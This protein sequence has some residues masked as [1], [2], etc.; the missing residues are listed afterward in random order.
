MG[1]ANT[2]PQ[3]GAKMGGVVGSSDGAAQQDAGAGAS[4]VG[5][6][7][8]GGPLLP[9]KLRQYVSVVRHAHRMDQEKGNPWRYSPDARLHPYDSPLTPKGRRT[10]ADVGKEL[11]RF[12]SVTAWS[13]I[14]SSPYLRCIQTASE[15]AKV[16]DLPIILDVEFGEVFDDVYMPGANNKPQYRE[17]SEIQKLMSQE[18]PGVTIVADE[19]GA[20]KHFG[21]LPTWPESFAAAQVRFLERYEATCIKGVERQRNAI[22]VSHGDAVMILLALLYPALEVKKIDYGGYFTAW[23]DTD[24]PTVSGDDG[25][26]KEA[27]WAKA[28]TQSLYKDQ[29]SVKVGPRVQYVM[30]H[31]QT[32]DYESTVM[33]E[34]AHEYVAIYRR[35]VKSDR[36]MWTMNPN[37]KKEAA[38]NMKKLQDLQIKEDDDGL[39]EPEQP[40][41]APVVMNLGGPQPI[42][43]PDAAAPA[44]GDRKATAEEMAVV[45]RKHKAETATSK[46]VKEL[47]GDIDRLRTHI[48]QDEEDEG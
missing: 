40:A 35:E 10:A 30:K 24:M 13:C 17:A 29:W 8:L 23:R 33:Q 21:E 32:V 37:M 19:K 15:I 38:D 42:H 45:R 5:V 28:Q 36:N 4:S 22:I 39:D 26:W 44:A 3:T 31:N 27:L 18:Y 1:C 14:I 34:Q 20:P 25:Q 46:L 47:R 2:K 16:L 6:E 43:S 41:P 7:Q 9:G 48:D 12:H 11:Q